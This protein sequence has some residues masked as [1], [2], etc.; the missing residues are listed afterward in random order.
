MANIRVIPCL[1]MQDKKLVKTVHFKNAQYIGDPLNTIKIYNTL[2]VDELILLDINQSSHTT[3]IDF[4]YLQSLTSECF[5]PMCYGGGVTSLDIAIKLFKLGFEKLSINTAVQTHP[6]L[7]KT[8]SSYF[9]S[10]SIVATIDCKKTFLSQYRISIHN[11]KRIKY[12]LLDYALY[13][14]NEGAGELLI[15]A[16]H[17]EGSMSGYDLELLS[18]LA[19]KISIPIIANCGAG[20]LQHMKEAFNKTGITAFAASSLFIYS[21]NLNGI[22]INYPDRNEIKTLFT[23]R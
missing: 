5:I 13:L 20:H 19:D 1:L 14:E 11:K 10:Q 7:I 21:G 9:G 8:L 6:F 22:L 23:D 15:N 17:K 16:I 12:S 2:F 18:K 4:N 3:A